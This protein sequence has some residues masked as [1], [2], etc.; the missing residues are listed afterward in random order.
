VANF[1]ISWTDK[2][3]FAFICG[4]RAG[5]TVADANAPY[6]RL[7]TV[8]SP[9]GLGGPS[10]RAVVIGNSEYTGDGEYR[11]PVYTYK[12]TY[13]RPMKDFS[14]FTARIDI[15]DSRL[16]F[17]GIEAG[18]FDPTKNLTY[19]IVQGN[20]L[21]VQGLAE[22][23]YVERDTGNPVVYSL[24][25]L[26]EYGPLLYS[27]SATAP[28]G[29]NTDME[30][31]FY[32]HLQVTG[33]VYSDSPINI[34]LLYNSGTIDSDIVTEEQTTLMT[35]LKGSDVVGSTA[36]PNLYYM[37]FVTPVQAVGGAILSDIPSKVA[38]IGPSEPADIKASPTCIYASTVYTPNNW[39]A[40]MGLY[41]NPNPDD[42]KGA[43]I[44]YVTAKFHIKSKENY[45]IT[46]WTVEAGRG[47]EIQ[48]QY[49]TL[50]DENYE[51]Y[52]YVNAKRVHVE[53]GLYTGMFAYIIA[54][55]LFDT[56]KMLMP[57]IPTEGAIY[58]TDGG[59]DNG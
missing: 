4:F 40:V 16:G 53:G 49:T 21:V 46:R 50:L 48:E 24:A 44:E 58:Y 26:K 31:L 7:D 39:P 14:G 6:I 41:V 37:Y 42:L 36:N 38:P 10:E 27:T 59:V 34:P 5:L 23:Q 20:I 51:F 32:L 13:A 43:D 3:W 56:P 17:I 54:T 57:V 55:V 25:D 1:T 45:A 30:V 18:A 9:I 35:F 2:Q 33:G 29:I 28:P 12:M 11:I 22:A 19:Q 8:L 15:S 52:I 47:W